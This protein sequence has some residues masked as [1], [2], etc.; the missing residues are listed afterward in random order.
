MVIN[1][2]IRRCDICQNYLAC[3]NE[4]VCIVTGKTYKVRGKLCWSS[5]NVVHLIS[6]KLCKERYVG[7]AFKDN[8][9]PCFRVYK[10]DIITGKDRCVVVKHFFTKCAEGNKV[11]NIEV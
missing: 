7:F 5:S 1:C 2:K 8:F 3:K 6:C 10:S 9:K 4:F 11:Q